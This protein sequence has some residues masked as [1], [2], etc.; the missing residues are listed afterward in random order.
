MEEKAQLRF[1]NAPCS[2]GT[3]EG[4][5]Q[6]VPY[7][8]MLDELKET[9]YEGSELGDY[10]YMPTD[11]VRLREEF[12]RRGLTL[13]GAFEGVYLREAS[14][15]GPGEARALRTARL[16]AA[17]ADLDP[18]WRPLLVLADEHSRD[19]LRLQRAGRIRPGEGLSPEEWRVVARG[20]RRIAQAVQE[21]TGLETVFHHH[22]ASFVETPEEI[23]TLVELTDIP[24]VFDTG[25]YLYG[26][27]EVEGEVV[28]EG[29]RRLASHVRYVHL[30]D[31]DPEVAH[32]ARR[33][34]W[35][36][37]EAV[38]RGLFTE[39]GRGAID[40][41]EVFRL[42]EA[43]GYRGFVTVEQDVFPGMGTPKESALRSR[44]YLRRVV[45]R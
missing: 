18:E 3:I 19:P 32:R 34:G 7:G 5:G 29:L 2:W 9:G 8:Q 16:M 45:G 40:F 21:A 4:I 28:V 42:L 30:K 24:L 33:E 43:M 11:P 14:E 23:A 13:L 35:D 17:L 44:E 15:H 1:G 41:T 36:Y 12:V 39:L 27:G 31:L 10:G 38:R 37:R 25:H 20:V 26:S 6:G 22:A